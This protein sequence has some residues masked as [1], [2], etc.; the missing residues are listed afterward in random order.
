MALGIAFESVQR[1]MDPRPV[2]FGQATVVAVV[3]LAGSEGYVKTV[4]PLA[5]AELD[6]FPNTAKLIY[7][8]AI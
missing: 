8:K 5:R 2:A 7:E 6:Y 4:G 1:L 3:G